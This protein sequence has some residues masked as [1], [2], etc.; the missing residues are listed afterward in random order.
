MFLTRPFANSLTSLIGVCALVSVS[1][2]AAR[3]S[4]TQERAAA[5][6][7]F[8]YDVVSIKPHRDSSSASGVYSSFNRPDYGIS[9]EN[10]TVAS[11]LQF[12]YQTEECRIADLPSW[13]K[14]DTYDIEAR[15]DDDAVASLKKLAPRDRLAVERQMLQVL[16]SDRFKLASHRETNEMPVYELAIAKSGPK[17]R[18]G[19]VLPEG[20][21]FG[22]G[23]TS[24]ADG[25]R[26]IST[27][28]AKID[29]LAE[30]LGGQVHRV[31]LNK[32]GLTERYAF[33]LVYFE[34]PNRAA[35]PGGEN[36]EGREPAALPP[37]SLPGATGR[38]LFDAIQEQLGLKLVPAKGPVEIIVID[39]IERPSPN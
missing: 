19:E 2:L 20:R 10:I 13:V 15:L 36:D 34:D 9:A 33:T 26:K 12:A 6:P 4:Q 23:S 16:L 38:S 29:S 11:L 32:T 27:R 25:N 21:E 24:Y 7:Q 5:A 39:H 1:A 22:I 28:G 14:A 17:I 30:I 37:A 3:P 31:V 18:P 8:Q 35:P